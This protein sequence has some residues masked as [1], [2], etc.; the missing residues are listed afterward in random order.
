MRYLFL[1][2]FISS[3]V[4]AFDLDG[5][6][7]EDTEK[8]FEASRDYLAKSGKS[9]TF[10]KEMIGNIRV[11]VSGENICFYAPEFSVT[12]KNGEKR[13]VG[14]YPVEYGKVQYLASN[15]SGVVIK[16]KYDGYET[17]EMLKFV[18]KNSY[19]L[20]QLSESE[21]ESGMHLYYKRVTNSEKYN[22]EF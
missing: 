14:P 20:I 8:S 7:I 2:I 21:V 12:T 11:E 17:I 3:K 15:E 4:L 6:W 19:R 5:V 16:S 22:C 1:L 18:N 13:S 10:F 9:E